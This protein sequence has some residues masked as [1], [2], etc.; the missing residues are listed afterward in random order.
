M[1]L[2]ITHSHFYMLKL[3]IGFRSNTIQ[4]F[5]AF[6]R[7]LWFAFYKSIERLEVVGDSKIVIDWFNQK[8]KLQ[9]PSLDPWKVN[10]RSLQEL[11]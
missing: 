9:V 5:L 8:R 4:K 6:Y 2:F 10:I 11:F 3:G 7:L 1:L